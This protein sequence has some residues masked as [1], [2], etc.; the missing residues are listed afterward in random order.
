MINIIHFLTYTIQQLLHQ[1]L[2][3]LS[4]HAFWMQLL[5]GIIVGMDGRLHRC[6]ECVCI[7]IN[8]QW[9]RFIGIEATEIATGY[10]WDDQRRRSEKRILRIVSTISYAHVQ[11][12]NE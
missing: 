8:T 7:A 12:M 9:V 6:M 3:K 5:I 1:N 4:L 11:C 2:P 10:E